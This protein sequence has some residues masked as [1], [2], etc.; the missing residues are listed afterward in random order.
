MLLCCASRAICHVAGPTSYMTHASHTTYTC[1]AT[2]AC[3]IQDDVVTL[4]RAESERLQQRLAS[5]RAE[6]QRLASELASERC[7]PVGHCRFK[8]L[9]VAAAVSGAAPTL[10][11]RHSQAETSRLLSL[12]IAS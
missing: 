5:A 1:R 11:L 8:P 9:C 3:R 4:A 12:F 6:Q 7:G 10:P 2:L